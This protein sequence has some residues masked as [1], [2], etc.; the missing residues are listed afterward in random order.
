M[1]EMNHYLGYSKEASSFNDDIELVETLIRVFNRN[2]DRTLEQFHND[3]DVK[4]LY[5]YYLKGILRNWELCRKWL[6]DP[7]FKPQ[8]KEDFKTLHGSSVISR[9][10]RKFQGEIREQKLKQLSELTNDDFLERVYEENIIYNSYLEVNKIIIS[11][12]SFDDTHNYTELLDKGWNVYSK[13]ILL[14][15]KRNLFAQY[16]RDGLNQYKRSYQEGR[17]DIDIVFKILSYIGSLFCGSSDP[18][19]NRYTNPNNKDEIGVELWNMMYPL[20]NDTGI[21]AINTYLY[22]FFNGVLLI[23]APNRNV[24]ADFSEICPGEFISHDIGHMVDLRNNDKILVMENNRQLYYKLINE[25]IL[26][27]NSNR[28]ATVQEKEILLV[29]LWWFLHEDAA[30]ETE[31]AYFQILNGERFQ[32]FF[33]RYEKQR[34]NNL[35]M[36]WLQYYEVMNEIVRCFRDTVGVSFRS[37]FGINSDVFDSYQSMQS[38]DPKVIDLPCAK[39][40]MWYLLYNVYHLDIDY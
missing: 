8:Y 28:D 19:V 17:L 21:F 4:Y 7:N 26:P 20:I 9:I 40:S 25:E 37:T 38:V 32:D 39:M 22:G 27:S 6:K 29:M 10:Q 16:V 3:P 5:N 34:F 15:Q 11:G 33:N 23:G 24:V 31:D 30:S 1:D 36:N 13:K 14:K 35:D 12:E 2:T 18:Q